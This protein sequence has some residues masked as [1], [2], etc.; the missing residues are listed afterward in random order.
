MEFKYTLQETL[1]ARFEGE[2]GKS[3]MID[4]YNHGITGGF[5]GFIYTYEIEKFFDEFENEIEDYFYDT[6]GSSWLN[7]CVT[8]GNI[9]DIS[10]L[11]T[12]LVYSFVELWVSAKVEE[13]ELMAV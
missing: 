6:L 11:K 3:E 5:H 7:D 13:E 10:E 8:G 12:Y 1:E 9:Q 4:I 2:D